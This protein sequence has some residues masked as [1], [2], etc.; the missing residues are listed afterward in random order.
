MSNSVVNFY[1]GPAILPESVKKQAVQ[2]IENFENTGLSILEISHRSKQFVAVMENARSLVKE[3][4]NLPENYEVLFLQ[5]G[6]SSQFYT[7]PYNLL[8][9][10]QT[11][12]YIDTGTWAKG[13]LEQA[14]LFGNVHIAGSSAGETYNHIPQTLSIPETAAYLHITTNN[15]IYGTQYHFSQNPK[16]FF[17]IDYPLIADMSSDILSREMDFSAF[18]LIY[19]GAQKN[20][21]I[22]GATMVVVNKDILGENARKLPD[23]VSYEKQIA[24]ASMKNT[25]SVFA[26]YVSYLTL[27]WIKEQGLKSLETAN[28]RKAKKLYEAIDTSSLFKGTVAIKDRSLM[29]V[30]F[31][32]NEKTLEPEFSK[33]A[34]ENGLAGLDGHRSVGGFRASIYNAMPESGIDT[35]IQL[36]KEFERTH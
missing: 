1:S 10:T 35:L 26:V 31:V 21:G 9:E 20:I 29:N 24:N 3:L 7:V 17:G 8:D 33:L 11:G 2:A 36:M 18:D 16:T 4:M 28:I 15:T 23:M 30:C 27:K 12:V 22:A 5:G 32:M 14:K 13:A 6:A 34:K 19:A 25:P